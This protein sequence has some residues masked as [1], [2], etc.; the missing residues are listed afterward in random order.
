MYLDWRACKSIN[1]GSTRSPIDSTVAKPLNLQI[2]SFWVKHYNVEVCKVVYFHFL[3]SWHMTTVLKAS[4]LPIFPSKTNVKVDNFSFLRRELYLKHYVSVTNWQLMIIKFYILYYLLFW[5]LWTLNMQI[6]SMYWTKVNSF[7]SSTD[8]RAH[9][10]RNV[11][12]VF[13]FY[14]W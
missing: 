3:K 6:I 12:I 14:Y 2:V 4:L 8:Q 5:I 9:I 10:K 13:P 11:T 7:S 1:L